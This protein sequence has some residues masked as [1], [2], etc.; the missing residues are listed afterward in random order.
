MG[1]WW[2]MHN[3]RRF[4]TRMPARAVCLAAGL[5]LLLARAGAAPAARPRV[6]IVA[7]INESSGCQA[8]TI[9]RLRQ[10]AVKHRSDVHLEVVDFGS[11]A[12][13]KRWRADGHNCE[14]IVVN[15]S[16]QFRIGRGN[17][18]RIV[19][20]KMPEGVRWTFED[21]DAV[22]EQELRSPGSAALSDADAVKLARRTPVAWRQARWKGKTVGEVIVGAQVVFRFTGAFAG[23]SAV[24]RA[25]ESAALLK[26]LYA[27]GLNAHQ[28]RLARGETAT[29]DPVG[30]VVID[31]EPVAVVTEA[32]ASLINRTPPQA[33]QFWAFNLREALRLLGR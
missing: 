8:E 24:Q 25:R 9:R 31:R 13:N 4:R 18:A 10:F 32:E 26:R 30:A 19:V 29:G 6:H 22:L 14:T 2:H 21:L 17:A 12:G 7:Y 16:S 28:I 20:L 15:G 3:L 33:T 11:E 23:K 5:L 1:E 27:G